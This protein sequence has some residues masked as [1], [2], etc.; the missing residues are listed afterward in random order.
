MD[1]I[2]ITALRLP[3]FITFKS[4]M[5][6]RHAGESRIASILNAVKCLLVYARDM[7]LEM[8]FLAAGTQ[9]LGERRVKEV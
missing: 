5:S 7:S 9:A 3:H 6:Q 1:D 8:I 4:R 2:P